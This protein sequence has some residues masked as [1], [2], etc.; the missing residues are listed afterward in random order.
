MLRTTGNNTGI[1]P[2]ESDQLFHMEQEHHQ[3]QETT[4]KRSKICDTIYKE[5]RIKYFEM[6][7]ANTGE[8]VV[9][10]GII[11]GR[12]TIE[13]TFEH[14]GID[15]KFQLHFCQKR[16]EGRI[17]IFLVWNKYSLDTFEDRFCD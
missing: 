6:E 9:H 16:L 4:D 2:K 12:F 5:L 14:S 8:I 7:R 10:I 11:D 1:I 17:Y 3:N 15:A 13:Q